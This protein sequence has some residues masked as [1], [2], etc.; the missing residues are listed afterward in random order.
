MPFG[1]KISQAT[2]QRLMNKNISGLEG[3]ECYVDDVIICSD[4]QLE[5][6]I[7]QKV[8]GA[9]STIDLATSELCHSIVE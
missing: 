6:S 2:F 1:M 9:K 5:R 4:W 3:C 7:F 8:L